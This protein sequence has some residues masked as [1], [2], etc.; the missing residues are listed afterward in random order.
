MMKF[1]VFLRLSLWFAI[2]IGVAAIDV[3]PASAQDEEFEPEVID[4]SPDDR[5][6]WSLRNVAAPL[7][8]ILLC[9]GNVTP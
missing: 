3:P 7:T 6:G 9:I 8:S 2:T 5:V 1:R 4:M